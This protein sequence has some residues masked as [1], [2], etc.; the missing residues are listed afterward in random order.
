MAAL[1]RE[2]RSVRCRYAVIAPPGPKKTGRLFRFFLPGVPLDEVEDE[3]DIEVLY[4]V[5]D[6]V[7]HELV[8]GVDLEDEPDDELLD[9][10]LRQV[11]SRLLSRRQELL[12]SDE[13]VVD[14]ARTVIAD[15][16]REEEFEQFFLR[17]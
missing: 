11:L 4:P 17:E 16:A 6:A 3:L 14:Q 9:R 5:G 13:P 10:L 1:P 7:E 12:A 2:T 15:D 8:T